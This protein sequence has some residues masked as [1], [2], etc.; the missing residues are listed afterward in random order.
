[1]G[2]EVRGDGEETLDA[3]EGVGGTSARDWQYLI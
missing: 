1:M 2:T 3:S